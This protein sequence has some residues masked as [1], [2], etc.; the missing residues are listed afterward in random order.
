MEKYEKLY[1]EVKN[2][3]AHAR[4]QE[5]ITYDQETLLL[6]Y[7]EDIKEEIDKE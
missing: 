3:F 5:Q 1:Q 7:L 6:T 2:I 4:Y